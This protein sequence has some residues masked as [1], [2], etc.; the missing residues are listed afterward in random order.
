MFRSPL[1][2]IAAAYALMSLVTLIAYGWDKFRAI[3]EKSRIRER[4]LHLLEFFGG[5][6]GAI[7]GR[8]L[9]RHKR[10]KLGFSIITGLI[11]LLHIGLWCMAYWFHTQ[12]LL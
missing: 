8:T 7:I 11:S 3:R 10:R 2:L 9:F 6:P 4:T 12:S 1:I 5:W